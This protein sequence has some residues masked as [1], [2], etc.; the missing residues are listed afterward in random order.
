MWQWILGCM[1]LLELWFSPDICPV[2][3]LLDHMIFI[4]RFL[5][6]LHTVIHSKYSSTEEWIKKMW[7]ICTMEYYSVIKNKIMSFATTWM[8]SIWLLSEANQ[9]EKDNHHMNSL[10]CRILKKK[11]QMNLSIKQKYSYRYRKQTYGHEGVKDGGVVNWE[12]GMDIYTL[13]VI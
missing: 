2:V 1:Y 9:T 13:V 4:P 3:R 8:D 7:Y 6:N 10:I 12:I 5:R 11:L